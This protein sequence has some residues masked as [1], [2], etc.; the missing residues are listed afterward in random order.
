[1]SELFNKNCPIRHVRKPVDK[2]VITSPLIQKL[3]RAKQRAHKKGNP[4]WKFLSKLLQQQMK[5][6]LKKLSNN[7]INN[8]VRGSHNWW[9]N[10]KTITG[11]S[12]QT[13]QS[14]VIN[15]AG[16]WLTSDQFVDKLNT[17]Y[18]E[19][20][21]STDINIPE[22]PPTNCDIYTDEIAV[23]NLLS[24][25]NT[26]KATHS[27]DFPSWLSRNNAHILCKPMTDIINAIITSGTFP[28]IWKTAEISPIQKVKNPSQYKDLRPISLLYHL[29]KIAE[30]AIVHH[31]RADLPTFTNQYAYTKG[32]STTD[33]LVRL[34][35]D[36]IKS[37]DDKET[38]ATQLLLLDFSKAF[39]RMRPDLAVE[40]LLKLEVRPA[41]ISVVKS[42]LTERQQRVKYCKHI[43]S[44]QQ[45]SVGVPQ[46]TIMGP[47]LWNC[48]VDDLCPSVET[49]KY[50]DDTTLY[51][52]IRKPDVVIT[53]STRK[54]ATIKYDKNPLQ[55]AAD[56]A[57]QWSDIN[58]MTLNTSKSQ[59]LTVSLC[60]QIDSEPIIIKGTAIEETSTAKLLGVTYDQHVKFSE[61]IDLGISKS[62]GAFHALV[63]LK[64]A[65]VDMQSLAQFYRS[66]ISPILTYAAPS[67]YP[68]ITKTNREK[69]EKYQRLCL[70]IIAPFIDH[71]PDRLNVLNIAEINTNLDNICRK[72]VDSIKQNAEHPLHHHTEHQIS[73]RSGRRLSAK[74]RTALFE[75]CLF[76]SYII[77]VIF[78]IFIHCHI[79][80]N[81]KELFCKRLVLTIFTH[82]TITV[83]HGL[84]CVHPH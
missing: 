79:P 22:I 18:V 77:I 1:M 10:V 81:L 62:K 31:L 71:Y 23:F 4:S 14:E 5:S 63:Q 26:R 58:S 32:L 36:I 34:T 61:H 54:Y 25:I 84:I 45:N 27:M 41:L 35:T 69:L 66:R 13:N 80:V 74:H 12:K 47:V 73:S 3:K 24:K 64:K 9:Q 55:S 59:V 56:Q 7:N 52:A 20:G 60:K 2:P 6:G 68:Q 29:S 72:Y 30:K 33:A 83:L 8:A 53:D 75:K 15:I 43:S 50:A 67:W 76:Y 46:G 57:A 38:I 19:Q 49:I 28:A 70:R 51:H 44:Y 21:D 78:F 17:Y 37:L 82:A 11:E 16:E 39:D 65:G 42:F 40:K 48:F